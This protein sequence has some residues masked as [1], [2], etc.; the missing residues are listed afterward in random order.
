MFTIFDA[1]IGDSI[2]SSSVSAFFDP[3]AGDV[4]G[5]MVMMQIGDRVPFEAWSVERTIVRIVTLHL[6]VRG[7]SETGSQL[8]LGLDR[9]LLP[10]AD[11]IQLSRIR[12]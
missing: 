2:G 7:G 6:D 3:E 4:V 10:S 11:A 5:N 1:S 8:T 9:N 12:N